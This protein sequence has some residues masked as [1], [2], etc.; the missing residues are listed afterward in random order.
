LEIAMPVSNP[1]ALVTN[2]NKRLVVHGL[3]V[4]NP[5]GTVEEPALK[6][7]IVVAPVIGA[8]LVATVNI[9]LWADTEF[10]VAT[11]VTGM[12]KVSMLPRL[13]AVTSKYAV[14]VPLEAG[15][16]N[17]PSPETAAG[18]VAAVGAVLAPVTVP[19][20]T[21]VSVVPPDPDTLVGR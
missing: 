4:R 19:L 8:K 12:K 1:V 6:L 17:K 21:A 16:K 13:S 10:D 2:G 15:T 9:P 5:S 18:E 7:G 20:V 3:K 14:A 11:S